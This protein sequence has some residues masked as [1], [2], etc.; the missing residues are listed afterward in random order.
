MTENMATNET[1]LLELYLA[2]IRK[3][4]PLTE[5]EK[6][7]LPH[8]LKAKDPHSTAR[9]VDAHLGDVLEIVREY[10]QLWERPRAMQA[11]ELLQEGASGLIYAV[12]THDWDHPEDFPAHMRNCV[13]L[14][15]DD[16]VIHNKFRFRYNEELI[17]TINEKYRQ[18]KA[19]GQIPRVSPPAR[20]ANYGERLNRMIEEKAPADEIRRYVSK[21]G[22][23]FTDT[24]W[25]ALAAL[26]GLADGKRRS[27]QAA[28]EITG[29]SME[30][31]YSL[32]ERL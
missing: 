12:K 20:D 26:M 1:D 28:S 22:A 24:E 2:E 25:Q 29:L 21:N 6:A 30:E 15:L 3:V 31:V 14:G 5:E 13:C 16:A 18:A 7:T 10:R 17:R 27:I 19:Q 11:D 9:M 4:E 23:V 32:R 8:L